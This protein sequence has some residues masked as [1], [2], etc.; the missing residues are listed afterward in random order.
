MSAG[1]LSLLLDIVLALLHQ[2]QLRVIYRDRVRWYAYLLDPSFPL[3]CSSSSSSL[4]FPLNLFLIFSISNT[5]YSLGL[6]TGRRSL[7]RDS[8]QHLHTI[9]L[10]SG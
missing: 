6:V 2:Q 5:N 7:P 9:H 3:I 4:Y 10:E 8:S 1:L